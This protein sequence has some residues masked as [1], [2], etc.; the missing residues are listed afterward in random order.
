MFKGG[1][2][3]YIVSINHIIHLEGIVYVNRM[4]IIILT[5]KA[6]TLA[7][8]VT[9][10]ISL[11]SVFSESVTTML[12][13]MGAIILFVHFVEAGL[14]T[15]RFGDRLMEPKFDKLMVLIFGVFHLLPF[16]VEEVKKEKA[17]KK[18]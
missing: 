5:G 18:K 2:L 7:F 13:W 1:G 11:F 10:L 15:K 6:I 12:G 16:L 4:K 14:F 3:T 8:W 9:V 17:A